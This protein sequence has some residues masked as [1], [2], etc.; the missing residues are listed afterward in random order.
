MDR[1]RR[2]QILAAARQLGP[3]DFN[4]LVR[5]VEEVRTRGRLRIWQEDLM[6]KLSE[7]SERASDGPADFI[8]VFDGAEPLPIPPR[9]V[10]REEFLGDPDQ[11]Y[12]SGA[13]IPNEWIA[14]AWEQS[15]EFRD[16]VTYEFEREASKVGEL[17]LIES[18]LKQLSNCLPLERM[19]EIYQ[20]VRASSPHRERE[21]ARHLNG[22]LATACRR[23]PAP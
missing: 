8:A 3:V 12:Y 9:T 13:S 4:R 7:T 2:E 1:T 16:N 20:K 22:S 5:S 19:V 17:V 15:P 10:T 14:E 11:W 18:S 23:F 21:F 6:A